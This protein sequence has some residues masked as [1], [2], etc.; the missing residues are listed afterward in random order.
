MYVVVHSKFANNIAP[1]HSFKMREYYQALSRRAIV[2]MY[3]GTGGSGRAVDV[4]HLR[5]RYD[6]KLTRDNIKFLCSVVVDSNTIYLIPND[7]DYFG[8]SGKYSM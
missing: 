6:D 7:S 2:S 8:E 5:T 4:L 1:D 3:W